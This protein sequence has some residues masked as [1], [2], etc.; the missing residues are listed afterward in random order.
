M[1]PK[2]GRAA[3]RHAACAC[4]VVSLGLLVAAVA[5]CGRSTTPVL[6]VDAGGDGEAPERHTPPA[7]PETAG[8]R[9]PAASD[10]AGARTPPPPD[11][12]ASRPRHEPYPFKRVVVLA[13]GI[14][15]YEK[16]RGT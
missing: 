14:N 6:I 8:A 4:A 16:L 12:A 7:A 9:A 1:N 15:Q 3:A 5:G 13:I 11:T 10:T 2:S